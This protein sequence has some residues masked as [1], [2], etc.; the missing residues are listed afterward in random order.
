MLRTR[1]LKFKLVNI[2]RLDFE[3]SPGLTLDDLKMMN[4]EKMRFFDLNTI[5]AREINKY[6]R[7]WLDGNLP[8]LRRLQLNYWWHHWTGDLLYGLPY[9]KWNPKRRARIFWWVLLHPFPNINFLLDPVRILRLLAM[10]AA[11][12]SGNESKWI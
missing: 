1:I 5:K 2:P 6:I 4:C 9:S 10:W 7:Y 3:K 8:N 11:Y 12:I